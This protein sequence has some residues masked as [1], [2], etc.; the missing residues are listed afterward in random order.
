MELFGFKNIARMELFLWDLELFLQ[1]QKRLGSHIVLKG[2]AA[3]QF[4]LPVEAQRTSVDIDM[5]FCGTDEDVQITLNNITEDLKDEGDFFQFHEY[6]PKNPKTNLQQLD[7]ILLVC[8][9]IGWMSRL[10]N[11][12]ML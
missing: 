9:M 12:M 8:K 4:Y 7:V 5:I 2:G 11:S 1:I 6:I 10:N 3:T